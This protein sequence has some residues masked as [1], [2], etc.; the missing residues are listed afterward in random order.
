MRKLITIASLL[1]MVFL[2]TGCG[3]STEDKLVGT[4]QWNPE[5]GQTSAFTFN[6]D[7]SLSMTYNTGSWGILTPTVVH[8][9]GTWKVSGENVVLAYTQST[10]ASDKLVGMVESEKLIAITDNAFTTI[11]ER[12]KT[13]TYTRKY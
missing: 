9:S 12:G 5:S 3:R 10:F 4:W 8:V 7:G 11:D 2:I 13:T 6:K 1:V